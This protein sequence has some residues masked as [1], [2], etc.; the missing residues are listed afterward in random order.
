MTN[1]NPNSD[2]MEMDMIEMDKKMMS[3]K[4]SDE[5]PPPDNGSLYCSMCN[6]LSSMYD[7]FDSPFITFFVI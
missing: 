2:D 1:R 3:E 4:E 7:R 6:W 5:P